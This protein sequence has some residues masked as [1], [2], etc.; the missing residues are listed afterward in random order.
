M[1][2]TPYDAIIIGAGMSGLAAGI[3]LARF[4]R[5]VCILER[6]T[7]IGGL[8]SF[9]RLGG[10]NF[11]VGLH[12]VTNFAPRA[13]RR[14]PL[15]VLLR[16][17]RLSWDDFALV[18]QI[19][20][21]IVFPGAALEFS[22]DRALVEAEIARVFPGQID[23]FRRLV[24]NLLDYDQLG[25][26]GH[27]GSSRAA[28]G[29]HLTD[30]LLVEMLLCPVLYYGGYREH[31]TDFQQ[32]S[33]LFRSI[34][35]EG[36]GRPLAGVRTILKALTRQFKALGG[37][38]RLRSGVSRIVTSAGRV[39]RVVL[40]NGEELEARRVMSS[41]GWQE[42]MRL[43]D[44]PGLH[45]EEPRGQ[46]SLVESISILDTAPRK[47]GYERTI[48]FFN[49]AERLRYARPA[50]LIELSSGVICSPDNF[51]YDQ[52]LGENAIRLTALANYDRW[53]ALDE[54]EYRRAKRDAYDRMT[55]AAIRH[56]PD[57]RPHVVQTDVF[58]PRTIH[59]YTGHDGGAL[60]GTPVKRYDG[61][62]PLA[63]LFICGT[64]QGLVGVIGAIMSG[65]TMANRHLLT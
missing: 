12:A 64:D 51:A 14:G 49:N 65:V 35:L 45:E 9:Y 11:D 28:L 10:R 32:F 61:T 18:P 39:E 44:P 31:D 22:N 38:L 40:D 46:I 33:I 7:T 43:C 27:Q 3:R 6:H 58:T 42:T 24:E 36:L 23:G 21:Q 63:N 57:F 52:P 4:D 54:D 17:L 15:P 8:N 50:G 41:A 59:R 55:A 30:P 19:R 25:V 2:Q 48:V 47:L 62:T 60:Y 13:S 5:R 16:Q 20:S 29:A 56:V 26:D 37:E 34:F 53:T 1:D